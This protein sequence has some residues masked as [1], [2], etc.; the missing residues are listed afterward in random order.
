MTMVT[1]HDDGINDVAGYPPAMTSLK[2]S[3]KA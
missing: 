1:C 3:L 2:L